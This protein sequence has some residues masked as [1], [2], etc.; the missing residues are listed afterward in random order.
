MPRPDKVECP[1][2]GTRNRKKNRN[3]MKK[4]FKTGFVGL[5]SLS[6]CLC[7]C[8]GGTDELP[9]GYQPGA[10]PIG[11]TPEV[12]TQT[13]GTDL[14]LANLN[15]F[16]ML[17]YCGE[18]GRMDITAPNFMYNQEV[19]KNPVSGA[20]EYSPKK[21]WPVGSASNS[22]VSF[23]AYAPYNAAG[24]K[25]PDITAKDH[26]VFTYKVPATEAGQNDLLYAAGMMYRYYDVQF[27]EDNAVKC[28]MRHALTKVTFKVKNTTGGPISVTGLTLT[29]QAEAKLR[30]GAMDATWKDYTGVTATF[31]GTASPGAPVSVPA[32]TTDE[33]TDI[34]TF[35]MLPDKTGATFSM[36]YTKD[37][38]SQTVAATALPDAPAW[39]MAKALTYTVT[40]KPGNI[41]TVGAY[42]SNYWRESSEN[43]TSLYLRLGPNN[44][45]QGD[46]Y[47]SDN[48]TS[49]GGYREYSD[50]T[51][52]QEDVAPVLTNPATGNE[53]SVIGIVFCAD[54]DRIGAAAK[55]ALAERGATPHG[56]V[57]ALTCTAKARWGD[58]AVDENSGGI[59]G[60]PFVTDA[61][62]VKQTYQNVD[63]YA[64]TQWILKN[65]A[66]ALQSTYAAFYKTSIYGTASDAS[67]SQYA[68]PYQ[69]TG[70]F[71]PSTGHWWDIVSNLGKVD[72]SG[73]QDYDGSEADQVPRFDDVT[74]VRATIAN[75]DYY[76]SRIEGA[77]LI[78]VNDNRGFYYWTSSE[79]DAGNAYNFFI[80]DEHG[81]A[82]NLFYSYE[83]DDVGNNYFVRPILAF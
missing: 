83:K 69:T 28:K 59:P 60:E 15:S 23:F 71:I 25:L 62:T 52:T 81:I 50:G 66:A 76:L 34:G 26:P 18:R 32:F 24:L 10:V 80:I 21:F 27:G 63:G 56:L 9:G 45:K 73:Y 65:H 61:K 37:G 79:K 12:E 41:A 5:L 14:T 46:Y 3:V 75:I 30:L 72:L 20:W 4:N 19:T 31:T 78:S 22:S 77:T 33:I 49:D 39:G 44:L 1:C 35:Y 51:S 55:A 2:P 82:M 11:F 48:T 6:L 47:Y 36:T 17:A 16:G 29:A 42:S 64:E 38:K 54:T 43:V 13:R 67:S 70:W 58:P 68:A 74:V 8:Q 57:M 7:A 40:L 53:R